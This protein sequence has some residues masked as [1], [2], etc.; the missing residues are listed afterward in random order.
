VLPVFLFVLYFIICCFLITKSRF[1]TGAGLGTKTTV[2]L[3]ALKVAAGVCLG[4]I[5]HFF[6]KGTNDYDL[7][8]KYGIEENY[9]LIHHPYRFFTDIFQSNYNDYGE[10]LGTTHSYWNDLRVN[11]IVKVLGFLNIFSRGNYY[12][13]SIFFNLFGFF[14][15]VALYRIFKNIF[16]C[17]K[18]AVIIGCFL[19]PSTLYFS[20]GIHKDLIIFA[21]MGLLCY[22]LYFSFR[23]HFTAKKITLIIVSFITILLIRNFVAL[24][25]LPFIAAWFMSE[26]LKLKPAMVYG[27]LILFMLTGTLFLHYFIPAADPLQMVTKRQEEFLGLPPG[28]TQYQMDT[29]HSTVKTFIMATPAAIRHA[30]ISPYRKPLSLLP[31]R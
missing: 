1:I 13:N 17:R 5:N 24:V 22:G 20:S 2:T 15:H 23:Q 19:L 29:L 10:F 18:T 12:V 14:G 28:S 3:F 6:F 26:K 30:F 8:N 4:L 21:S 7:Y 25:L 11:I 27:V 16:P 31:K 9:N